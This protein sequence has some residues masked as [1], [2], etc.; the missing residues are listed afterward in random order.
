MSGLVFKGDV[1]YSTGEYLPAPYI[2]KIFVTEDGLD[3]ESF[4]F[5]DDYNDV[6]LINSDKDITNSK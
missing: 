2:N 3:I 6:D 5:L 4:I 1:I